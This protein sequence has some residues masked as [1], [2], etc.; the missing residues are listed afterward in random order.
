M[1][2]F[3]NGFSCSK[4]IMKWVI[5]SLIA[6][7]ICQCFMALF[8]MTHAVA[9]VVITP[10]GRDVK[11]RT[12]NAAFFPGRTLELAQDMGEEESDPGIYD[13][14]DEPYEGEEPYGDD[15]PETDDDPGLGEEPYEEGPEKREKPYQDPGDN[16]DDRSEDGLDDISPES[17]APEKKLQPLYKE[18]EENY[19]KGNYHDALDAFFAV[20]DQSESSAVIQAMLWNIA[21][22]YETLSKKKHAVIYYNLYLDSGPSSEDEEK[23]LKKIKALT[24]KSE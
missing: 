1:N 11:I 16:G 21:Q 14:E 6:I 4:K 20:K 23:A 15:F 17:I 10:D 18:G 12:Q 19:L 9:S 7:P 2:V 3:N 5:Q 13:H 24:G 22:C 8:L